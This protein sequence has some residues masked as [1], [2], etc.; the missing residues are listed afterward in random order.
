MRG[1]AFCI[2]Q[3]CYHSLKTWPRLT[4]VRLL[5]PILSSAAV[6]QESLFPPLLALHLL[7]VRQGDQ[8]LLR[9]LLLQ[10]LSPCWNSPDA[11]SGHL[12]LLTI[13]QL[14]F[15]SMYLFPLALPS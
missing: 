2:A 14:P 11:A 6:L 15:I 9:W 7:P 12:H 10:S 4:T 3:I 5:D 13:L 8:A 1:L